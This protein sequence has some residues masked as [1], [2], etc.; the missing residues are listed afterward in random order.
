[1][2]SYNSAKEHALALARINMDLLVSENFDTQRALRGCYAVASLLGDEENKEWIDNELSGYGRDYEIEKLP[3][4]RRFR[5][6][7][8][9]IV[10][11]CG[12]TDSIHRIQHAVTSKEPLE[13][14]DT[15]FSKSTK[16]NPDWCY[17]I[18][19]SVQDK[20]LKYLLE[21]I[22][23]VEY[24]GKAYSIMENIRKEVDE[25]LSKINSKI[26]SELQLISNGINSEDPA[27]RSQVTHSCRRV[28]KVLADE[29]FPSKDEPYLDSQNIKRSV[30]E[31][32]YMN[33][34]LAFLEINGSIKLIR[35]QIQYLASYFDSLRELSGKGE[36]SD[37]SKFETELVVIHTYL[38]ISQV[39]HYWSIPEKNIK[40]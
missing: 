31:D 35:N 5:V 36:H 27:E 40:K 17:T 9:K 22:T 38:L 12:V 34:L 3:N 24:S 23:H 32:A 26:N 39:L 8:G 25:K 7:R 6:N 11:N 28:L 1:M 30:K 18:L 15:D 10:E 33:R 13:S 4:T 20:C 14:W 37:I 16:F 21:T 2:G 19:S 29:V